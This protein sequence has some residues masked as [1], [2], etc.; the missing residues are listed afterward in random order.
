MNS[1]KKKKIKYSKDANM[2]AT[3]LVSK[4]FHQYMLIIANKTLDEFDLSDEKRKE[5]IE[6]L[7]KRSD[8]ILTDKT[9]SKI[10]KDLKTRD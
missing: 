9:I 3:I 2:T 6:E 8:K 5:V 4:L 7:D 10:Y 1:L